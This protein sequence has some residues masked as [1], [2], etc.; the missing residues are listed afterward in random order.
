MAAGVQSLV[1]LSG[2]RAMDTVA[3]GKGGG[4]FH[5]AAEQSLAQ[6]K[7]EFFLDNLLVRI[8]SIIEMILANWPLNCLFQVPLIYRPRRR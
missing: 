6:V 2:L 5:R 8:H 1:Q 3:A 7:R 4:M